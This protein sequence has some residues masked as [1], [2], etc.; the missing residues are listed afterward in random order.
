MLCIVLCTSMYGKKYKFDVIYLFIV[1]ILLGVSINQTEC[2]AT[3][4]CALSIGKATYRT[5]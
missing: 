2:Q 3:P 4:V 5:D 1:M